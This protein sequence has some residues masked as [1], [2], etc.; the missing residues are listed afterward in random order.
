MG[1]FRFKKDPQGDFINADKSLKIPPFADIRELMAASA[2]ME[3]CEENNVLPDR[4][5]I[6]Q[7]VQPGS[8]LGGA[9]PK[10]NVVDTDGTLY[11]AKFPSRK[12][13]YDVGLWEHF[14]HLLA[15]KA[16]INAA[17][18]KVLATGG[19]HHTLEENLQELYRRVAFNISIGNSDDHFRN[20]GFLLT[21][22]GWTLSPAYDMNPTLNDCQSLLVSATSNR[23][24]LGILLDACEDYM[25]NRKTAERIVFEVIEAVKDWRKAAV[26]HG[27][28]KREIDIFA[29]V[30]DEW[31]QLGTSQRLSNPV[32]R[33]VN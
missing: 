5:W 31:C 13:D 10:A 14:A 30:L 3:R 8:S 29:G 2:E 12:D 27:I 28:S 21:A 11:V 25:L 33:C 9:R 7:L 15:T 23:A 18:T 20:H 17:E 26:R 4:K 6:A 1:A 19:R 22:K 32:R 24:E 16:G